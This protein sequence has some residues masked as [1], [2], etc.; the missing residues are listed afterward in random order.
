MLII[1]LAGPVPAPGEAMFQEKPAAKI[2]TFDL[3]VK[4][5]VPVQIRLCID[6]LHT[7]LSVDSFYIRIVERIN[8]YSQAE[9]VLGNPV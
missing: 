8:I 9:P 7:P 4:V 6:R 3:I 1:L 5:F 2:F